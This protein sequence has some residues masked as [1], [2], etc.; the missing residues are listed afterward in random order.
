VVGIHLLIQEINSGT[1]H[2]I[3]D[4]IHFGLIAAFGKI[5]NAFYESVGHRRRIMIY[6]GFWQLVNCAQ[7]SSNSSRWREYDDD[8]GSD[9]SRAAWQPVALQG[10]A[11]GGGVALPDE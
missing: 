9:D 7:A 8:Y 4:G 3:D 10:L 5:R 1:F 6:G 2:G 11:A